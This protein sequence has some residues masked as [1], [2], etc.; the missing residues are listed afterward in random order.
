MLLSTH[1]DIEHE[2]R[3]RKGLFF[4][5]NGTAGIWRKTA[6]ESA[7]GWASDTVTEDLD[8]SYRA[9]MAGWRFVYASRVEV[10]SELPVTLSDFRRQQDRWGKGAIQTARKLL[11]KIM[12]S[13]LPIPVKIEAVA[14]LMANVCWV[15][16]FIATLT[17][18][19]MLLN[20]IGIGVYHI[21]WLDLPLFLLA[22]VAVMAYYMIYEL[23]SGRKGML[24]VLPLLPAASIGLAPF[25]SLTVVKGLVQ[26]GGVFERTPKFGITDSR[27][28]TFH[29]TFQSQVVI[30]LLMNIPLLIY[31]LVPVLFA[32][33]RGT[34]PAIP[35]LCFFP[36]GFFIVM[37]NDAFELLK[38]SRK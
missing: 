10:L 25:F 36:L 34:W 4:N 8:L 21:L 6:I 27:P 20:R 16:G 22:G 12:A 11:P 3:Y 9:Q 15:F 35:F 32:W 26:K 5:F 33:H 14:H 24:W 13:S 31:T 7:G 30:H 37:A 23:R 18:Y 1:F 28:A 29:F 38:M 19:P 2:V 17:L